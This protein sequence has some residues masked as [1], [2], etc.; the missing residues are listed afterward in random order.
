M[1]LAL[2]ASPSTQVSIPISHCCCLP[3]ACLPRR[4]KVRCTKKSVNNR[5]SQRNPCKS[6][7]SYSPRL[8][9]SVLLAAPTRHPSLR[10]TPG[11][12]RVVGNNNTTRHR[13]TDG[14]WGLAENIFSHGG[15]CVQIGKH[16]LQPPTPP[17]SL[18]DCAHMVLQSTIVVRV[19]GVCKNGVAYI[20][21][22]ENRLKAGRSRSWLQ[23]QFPVSN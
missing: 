6:S 23:A 1:L 12:Y 21:R 15:T 18:F 20:G 17:P 22:C 16:E 13:R 9:S 14:T 19:S 3:P 7:Q 11:L 10:P 4:C 5:R 8:P 2:A